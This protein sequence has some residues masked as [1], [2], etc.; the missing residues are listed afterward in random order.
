MTTVALATAQ[1]LP[2]TPPLTGPFWSYVV[3][4][5]VFFVAFAATYL[6]YR[7]FADD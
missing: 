2:A 3:P 1:P 5:L 7:H 4:A 6:L